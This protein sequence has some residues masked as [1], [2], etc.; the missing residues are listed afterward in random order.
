MLMP[1]YLL[2]HIICLNTGQIVAS[3]VLGVCIPQIMAFAP[4]LIMVRVGLGPTVEES[5]I[6]L[7]ADVSSHD[8]ELQTSRPLAVSVTV[9]HTRTVSPSGA[10]GGDPNAGLASE[11]MKR[12]GCAL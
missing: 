6:T 3:N 4:L 5:H 10:K 9:S 2:A 7:Q 11:D 1:I 12:S 8:V